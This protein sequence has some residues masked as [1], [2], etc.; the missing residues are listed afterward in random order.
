MGDDDGII[1]GIADGLCVG[2]C[3]LTNP[4]FCGIYVGDDVD[5][6]TVGWDVEG[7][8]E[9]ADVVGGGEGFAYGC[10]VGMRDG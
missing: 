5:G 1:V 3:V 9:G 2:R 7:V 8:D 6:T 4:T 10:N